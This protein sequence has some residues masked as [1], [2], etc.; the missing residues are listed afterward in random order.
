MMPKGKV[1]QGAGGVK[2]DAERGRKGSEA[3]EAQG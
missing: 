1:S 3:G 2:K